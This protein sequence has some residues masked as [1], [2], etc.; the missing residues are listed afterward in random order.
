MLSENG[1]LSARQQHLEEIIFAYEKALDAGQ[2]LDRQRLLDLHAELASELRSYF[3]D[4]DRFQ[5]S[6]QSTVDVR[7]AVLVESFGDYEVIEE[8]DRGGMGV[9]LRSRDKELGR[10]LAIK[11]MRPEHK[12][13]PA[14][15]NRFLKEAEICGQLQHPGIVPVHE[16]GRLP[17]GRPYFT[18]RLVHGK[19]L[20]TLLERRPTAEELPHLLAV[21]DQ[22]C[23][24]MEYA[25]GRHVI[26]RDLKPANIMVG[27]HG[28]VQVIDWGMAK[29]LG[30]NGASP[31]PTHQSTPGEENEGGATVEYLTNERSQTGAVMGTL[32]YM[33]PEQAQGRVNE[34]D[35]R[36]DVFSLGAVLCEILTGRP[37]YVGGDLLARAQAADL[38]GALVAL[39]SCGADEQLVYIAM[40]CLSSNPAYRPQNAG[41][42]AREL[43][44][45]LDFLSANPQRTAEGKARAA[46]EQLKAAQEQA[47]A[48]TAR[49]AAADRRLKI[50]YNWLKG[51]AAALVIAVGLLG[52]TALRSSP[53]SS[54]DLAFSKQA[55]ANVSKPSTDSAPSGKIPA[56]RQA[57]DRQENQARVANAIPHGLSSHPYQFARPSPFTQRSL[58]D[59]RTPSWPGISVYRPTIPG[60][61]DAT[62]LDSAGIPGILNNHEFVSPFGATDFPHAAVAPDIQILQ[63]ASR[64]S[65]SLRSVESLGFKPFPQFMPREPIPFS[66]KMSSLRWPARIGIR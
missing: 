66:P 17:D 31:L 61:R 6:A 13:D 10:E 11:V 20:A 24:A 38:A 36:C 45:Y 42:V 32:P 1:S 8:I 65:Q 33:A 47:I 40:H 2:P 58:G 56:P 48:A 54:A 43:R 14:L 41:E 26:H 27:I 25:H 64:Y 35:S 19:T 51:A 23:R 52:W 46:E 5:L 59:V 16:R 39:D 62:A 3:A 60:F 28:D 57:E 12:D 18:M 4:L 9:L 63:N 7:D 34:L 30:E 44:E 49:A 53:K 22:A 15:V 55:V 21:F 37:P 50:A 29:D